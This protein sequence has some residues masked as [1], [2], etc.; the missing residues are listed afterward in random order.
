[1]SVIR[2]VM[3]LGHRLRVAACVS[4]RRGLNVA[5]PRVPVRRMGLMRGVSVV[6]SRGRGVR[7][8]VHERKTDWQVGSL[9]ENLILSCADE[10]LLR[11]LGGLPSQD[12]MMSH[13]RKSRAALW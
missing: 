5:M 9:L 3:A 12:G 2:I 6:R 1:M 11:E 8:T 4:C 10:S 13:G 7:V